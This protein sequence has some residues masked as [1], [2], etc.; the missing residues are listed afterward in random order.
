MTDKSKPATPVPPDT[1]FELV[2]QLPLIHIR[3]KKQLGAALRMVDRLLRDELDDGQDAYLDALTDLI[4]TYERKHVVIPDASEA[5]VLRVLMSSN[6]LSQSTL[7]K[8]VG[9]SQSTISAVLNGTRSLTKSQIES[10]SKCFHLS[11]A[12]FFPA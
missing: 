8:R 5:D 11:P 9:I 7:A 2:K 6:G 3:N 1:Y 10:L 12:A 4:E